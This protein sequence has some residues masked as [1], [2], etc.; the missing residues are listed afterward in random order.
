[1]KLTRRLV[2]QRARVPMTALKTK[3]LTDGQ[4]R[5]IV[6]LGSSSSNVP[7]MIYD[8]AGSSVAELRAAAAA[9]RLDVLYVDY[10]QLLSAPGRERWEIVTAISMAL[11][12]MAQQLGVAVVALSQITAANKDRK[13]KPDK[14]D[15]RESKQLKQ[16][17]DIIIMLGLEDPDDPDSF[18]WLHVTKNKDGPLSSVC[19]RFDAEHMDFSAT[20]SRVYR[21]PSSRSKVKKNFKEADEEDTPFEQEGLPL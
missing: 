8:A 4:L 6:A 1:M 5:D 17:A 7:L 15:L 20:D 18:R 19:L 13:S 10:V 11:H 9:D 12:T 16:D 14:D 2:A 3:Q 21:P